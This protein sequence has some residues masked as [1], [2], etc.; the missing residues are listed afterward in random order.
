MKKVAIRCAFLLVLLYVL[1]PTVFAEQSEAAYGAALAD[2]VAVE[3]A[4]IEG[5]LSELQAAIPSEVASLLPESFF[6]KDLTQMAEGI[7][8]ASAPRAVLSVIGKLTGLSLRENLSLLAKICGVLIL[9]AV[10]RAITANPNT[11]GSV[12]KALSFCATLSLVVVIFSLQRSRF[13]E[14]SAYFSTVQTLS[15]A[16]LPMMGALYAMGGNMGAAVANHGVMTA[17]LSILQ[18]VI[19]GTVLP[20]ASICLAMALLDA[21]SGKLS[22]RPLCGL[23]KRTYSLLFSFLMLLLC[24][25]L[26]IQTTLAK[27]SDTLALRTARFAAGSFLP[28]VGGSISEALRTVS[29]SVQYLRSVTGSGAI[30]VLLFAFLPVFLSILLTRIVFLLSSSAAKLLGCEGEDKILSELASV[31]GYFL[32]VIA[33]IFVM[34]VFSLTLFARCATAGG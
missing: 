23:I 31:Y 17:F 9:S 21:V 8:Q 16:M 15:C 14:I 12:G 24:G 10:F 11:A 30:L 2:D 27:G 20:I 1:T 6:S 28:V 29:G 18:T 34:T 13:S 4:A 32:A 33:S 19:S 22:L 5:E 26:G 25:V 3:G 7:E